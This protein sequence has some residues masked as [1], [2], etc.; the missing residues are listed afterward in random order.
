[1]TTSGEENKSPWSLTGDASEMAELFKQFSE[2][3]ASLRQTRYQNGVAE[4]GM[5]TFLGNDVIRMMMEELA[6]TANYCEMQFVKLMLLQQ[7]LVAELGPVDG[8]QITIGLEAFKGT[9][10]GWGQS[11]S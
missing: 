7:Y 4:Y 1:M 5:F 2:E 8:D 10:E 6:D 9:K 3:F 11:G